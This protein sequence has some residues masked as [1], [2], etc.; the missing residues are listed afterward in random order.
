MDSPRLVVTALAALATLGLA[1][2]GPHRAGGPPNRG[3]PEVGV[4]TLQAEP[5]TLTTELPGRTSPFEVSDVRPQIGGIVKARLF[6]E[7]GLVRA[8]QVLYRID[9][10]TYQAAYDQARAQLASALANVATTQIKA[11]RYAGLVKINAV[12]K[13]DFDDAQAAYKQ[14]AA[15]VQ[16]QK[17]ATE[18]ARINLG[19]TRVTAPISG[20]I[21]TS[22][23]T[24]GALVTADQATA[25]STIQRLDPIYVDVTQSASDELRLRRE[26]DAGRVSRRGPGA[27]AVRLK[28]GDGTDYGQEGRLQFTDVTVDQ[29]TGAVTL[30][31]VFRN[32]AALLLPGL[33]VRAVIVEGVQPDGLLAPQ[34][35][36]ARDEK[37]E[38]TALV[39]DST[40]HAQIRTLTT[41]RAV[42]DK[43]LVTQGLAP[44]DRLIVEGLQ[45]VKPGQAVRAVPAG[46]PPSSPHA[47]AAPG[48]H[49]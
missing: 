35:G 12:S 32:P 31:A 16:Q 17:A 9:P 1:G 46:S 38:P 23:V 41:G 18:A 49:R 45:N 39:V 7:G 37:G 42:G 44:G 21:G 6:Q 25:L 4:V 27:L 10:A 3:P 43:W 47:P 28:L 24:V 20:R 29:T 15:S 34:Q 30:R 33:Y 14:A 26:V 19:Y 2:C 13:Q 22:A 8:G 5:V 40:G 48:G 36:V 11:Q